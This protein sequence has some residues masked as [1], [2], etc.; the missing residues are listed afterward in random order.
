M[1]EPNDGP[2]LAD[3]K[4][5][6]GAADASA[7]E[8]QPLRVCVAAAFGA[9]A[10]VSTRSAPQDRVM[11]LDADNFDFV[12]ERFGPAFAIELED[13]VDA[14]APR[15]KVSLRWSKLAALRPSEIAQAVPELCGLLE[16]HRVLDR[17]GTGGSALAA[18]LGR[19]L[20]RSH[21]VA[22]VLEPLDR[23][24]TGAKVEAPSA[25]PA[26]TVVEE[27]APDSLSPL[28]DMVAAE[29]QPAAAKAPERNTSAL[30]N[31][32]AGISA[33]RS[34][35][36]GSGVEAARARVR[37][38]FSRL[39][40][41][42]LEH[43]EVQ[44]LE[45]LWRGLKV[46]LQAGSRAKDVQLFVAFLD[47]N[48]EH[49]LDEILGQDFDLLC[50]DREVDASANGLDSLER[51]AALGAEY[52]TPVL[53][54]AVPGLLGLDRWHALNALQ[55]KLLLVDHPALSALQLRAARAVTRWVA[56]VGN[57]L[58]IRAPH[59]AATSRLK[60]M[61][62]E[63]PKSDAAFVLMP[64]TFG[65]AAAVMR[66]VAREGHPFAFTG[67]DRGALSDLEVHHVEALD[68]AIA[69]W[70][71]VGSDAQD[72]AAEVGVALWAPIKNRAV[73]V[74]ASA[75][76]LFRG[77]EAAR[78]ATPKARHALSEALF[79]SRLTRVL[80]ETKRRFQDLP[81]AAYA[82]RLRVA[83]L[84]LFPNAAPPGPTLDVKIAGK[85]LTVTIDPRRY[86]SLQVPELSLEIAR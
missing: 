39:L 15:I 85:T 67:P 51:I 31:R 41:A 13:P 56:L 19:V 22:A 69:T 44:R 35:A 50:L 72:A 61:G 54:N 58:R 24:T 16:A 76:L 83:L 36:Q 38:L 81:D 1:T 9:I 82:E 8:R 62:F 75:P 74:L 71:L 48:E 27:R 57:P 68:A 70:D 46:L 73:A 23:P 49:R 52:Q 59:D 10:E 65:L 2:K 55:Q 7:S 29:E 11:A 40:S 20:P 6:F 21:W 60:E 30:V 12:F 14:R 80:R 43:P 78:G 32:L 28:F 3:F 33:G 53:L 5:H 37:Q 47:A 26:A 4:V 79:L 42:V 18:N 66:G 63:Q 64:A 17:A 45:G 86:G 77:E 34:I 25:P 84:E